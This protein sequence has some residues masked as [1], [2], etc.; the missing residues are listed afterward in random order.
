MG[1]QDRFATWLDHQIERLPAL[2]LWL[3]RHLH[4][5]GIHGPYA[6]HLARTRLAPTIAVGLTVLLALVAALLITRWRARRWREDQGP[7]T[8]RA[9]TLSAAGG[10]P[11][12]R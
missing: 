12:S 6:R 3:E 1:W 5:M 9:R 8:T 11:P 2:D 7:A 4:A 10:R